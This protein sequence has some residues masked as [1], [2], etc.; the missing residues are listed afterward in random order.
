MINHGLFSTFFI[1]RVKSEITLDDPTRGR[2]A[3]L[4]QTWRDSDNNNRESL[5]DSFVKQAVSYIQ[6]VPPPKTT[7][8]GVYPLYEDF[9]YSQVISVLYLVPPAADLNDTAIGRF[10]PAKLLA[11]LRQRNLT[12]GILTNGAVWRLYCC[13]SSRPYE[14][15]VELNLAA[16]L[17]QA[18]EGE[19][20]LFE[21]FFHKDAF[22]KEE[23]ERDEE[24]DN[25][26]KAGGVFKCRL[27]RDREASEKILDD[28]VKKPL[29]YQVDE[30]LGY[31]CNGFIADT[32]RQGE[33]YTDEERQEIFQS[34][35]RLVYRCLFLFYAEARSLLPS[36][37]DKAEVYARH[38]IGALCQE[39]RLF[40]W[41]KRQDVENYDLWQHLRGLIHAVNDG[42]PEYGIMGYNGGLFDDE[43]IPFLGRQRLRNDFLARSLYLLAYVEPADGDP[44]H[45]YAI[46]YK[47]LE[48]RHLGELYENIL[49]FTVT[50]ADADRIRRRT[51]KG[52]E[53]LL[54]SETS[55]QKGDTLI[56]K[57]S[58]YF[59]ASA[60]ERK[61]TGSFYT[62]EALVRFLNQK[63]SSRCGR[64]FYR[65]TSPAWPSFWNRLEK[66]WM[67]VLVG[68]RSRRQLL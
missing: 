29:L 61:Q 13:K 16:V 36:E 8:P 19:Y 22:E 5:W 50:L 68:A 47:D 41:G 12:W 63:A 54:A 31:L 44:Q 4:T 40:H 67:G 57:G 26:E 11:A 9:S 23:T 21:R 43:A 7:I 27:D 25:Q 37:A 64:S 3:T 49:E 38:S 56:K 18:D 58:V 15:F 1:Q 39:A 42:D 48:V 66:E 45:E 32:H 65:A 52:I 10:W 46:P 53:I 60:L 2:L 33:E 28:E 6:F 51:K 24:E 55:Q 17:E 14:D 35:V 30:I 59:G 34:A 20:G 62:P